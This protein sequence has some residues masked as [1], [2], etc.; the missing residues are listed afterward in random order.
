MN[1]EHLMAGI[2]TATT[3]MAVGTTVLALATIWLATGTRSLAEGTESLVKAARAEGEQNAAANQRSYALALHQIELHSKVEVYETIVGYMD[4][5]MLRIEGK[6]SALGFQ[7]VGDTVGTPF[8]REDK[9]K[10]TSQIF[11]KLALHG[12]LDITTDFA[13][14]LQRLTHIGIELDALESYDAYGNVQAIHDPAL[15]ASSQS[16]FD[17]HYAWLK[18]WYLQTLAKIVAELRPDADSFEKGI[19][20]TTA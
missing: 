5:D 3:V 18:D 16:I 12:T 14:W 15:L 17:I 10:L 19:R 7:F 6:V 11:I 8:S 9:M 1:G 4:D 2:D 20:P 13:T